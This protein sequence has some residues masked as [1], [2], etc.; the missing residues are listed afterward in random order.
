MRKVSENSRLQRRC[1]LDLNP[2]QSNVIDFA[3]VYKLDMFLLDCQDYRDYYRDPA[4]RMHMPARFA[5]FHGTCGIREDTVLKRLEKPPKYLAERKPVIYPQARN[6]E[7]ALGRPCA[8]FMWP[9]GS[10]DS[11]KCFKR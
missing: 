8:D 2:R 9:R 6:T 11:S 4:G 3:S 1:I 5:S 7:M 10:K